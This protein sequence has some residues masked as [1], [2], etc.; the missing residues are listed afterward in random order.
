MTSSAPRTTALEPS[1][2]RAP[3]HSVQRLRRSEAHVFFCRLINISA[4]PTKSEQIPKNTVIIR[5]AVLAM[6]KDQKNKAPVSQQTTPHSTA[7]T[8]T[9]NMKHGTPMRMPKPSAGTPSM[10]A[11]RFPKSDARIGCINARGRRRTSLLSDAPPAMPQMERRRNRR[12]HWSSMVRL[13]N[14]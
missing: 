1:A 5:S 12:V 14:L 13:L 2:D 4:A 9:R 6:F 3:R 11:P 7:S 10:K 8:R